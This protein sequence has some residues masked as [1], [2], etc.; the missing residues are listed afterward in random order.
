MERAIA[1]SSKQKWQRRLFARTLKGQTV[2]DESYVDGEWE[3]I[4]AFDLT[5]EGPMAS[6]SLVTRRSRSG[7]FKELT[8]EEADALP[9]VSGF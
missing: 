5:I 7:S 8:A 3:Y 4:L 9:R 2:Y 1:A 6:P